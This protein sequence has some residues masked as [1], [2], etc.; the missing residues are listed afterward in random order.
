MKE[1][2]PKGENCLIEEDFMRAC[3]L[4]AFISIL[5]N[6][7]PIEI[8]ADILRS[9]YREKSQEL[10]FCNQNGLPIEACQIIEQIELSGI[11]QK[12]NTAKGTYYKFSEDL[13]AEF[14]ASIYLYRYKNTKMINNIEKNESALTKGLRDALTQAKEYF[15]YDE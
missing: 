4:A 12:M 3:L 14:L 11:I 6:Y 8:S 1:V 7:F 15:A 10:P 5:D 9:H 13:I 2:C